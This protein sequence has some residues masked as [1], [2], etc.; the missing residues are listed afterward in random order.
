MVFILGLQYTTTASLPRCKTPLTS[1]LLCDTKQSDSEFPVMLDLRGIQ[2]TSSLP[3][4]PGPLWSG[5]VAPDKVQSMGQI[6]LN[7]VIMLN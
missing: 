7:C 5:V 1:V 6:E 3:S 4:L 2:S